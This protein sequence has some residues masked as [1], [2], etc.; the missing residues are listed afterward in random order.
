MA[1][2]HN[3]TVNLF[4]HVILNFTPEHT[5]KSLKLYQVSRGFKQAVTEAM[6]YQFDQSHFRIDRLNTD[7]MQIEESKMED[8]AR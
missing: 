4:T 1:E 5:V 6:K 8:I 7:I 3:W 2:Q